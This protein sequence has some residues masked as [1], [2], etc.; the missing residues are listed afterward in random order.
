[1]AQTFAELGLRDE[2]ARAAAAAGYARP[3]AVQRGAIPVLRRGGNAVLHAS[4]GSGVLA[5]Y[6]LPLVDRLAVE[7]NVRATGPRALV[8]VPSGALA[9]PTATSMA[10][11]ARAVGLLVV[12]EGPGWPAIPADIM[13]LSVPA[14]LQGLQTSSL[15]LEQLESLVLDGLVASFGLFG[16]EAIESLLVTVPREA[17]RIIVAESA[18]S[19]VDDFVERHVRRAL[20]VPPRS[21]ADR[22][23]GPAARAPVPSNVLGYLIVSEIEKTATVAA[24]LST[25][26][27]NRN[28]L[29][30]CRT[31]LVADRVLSELS[32]RGFQARPVESGSSTLELAA[33]AGAGTG[34]APHISHDVPLDHEMLLERHPESGIVVVTPRELPHL[35]R[36][37][38][39]A[40]F[41]LQPLALHAPKRTEL[42]QFRERLRRAAQD[43]DLSA[44]IL[45]L[46]PLLEELS[47]LE[48]AAAAVGLL[49]RTP[50]IA[51]PASPPVSEPAA[52]VGPQPPA[53]VRLFISVGTRDNLRPGDLVGAITGEAA[54]PGPAVGRVDIRDTYSIVEVTSEH[55]EKVLQALNGVTLKGRSVRAD[56]DRKGSAG[57]SP[58][59]RGPGE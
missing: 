18:S 21:I 50:Q 19:E 31:P 23:A 34:A 7:Q 5:A 47:A 44:Q 24:L 12:G 46:E 51:T 43:E 29:L 57:S 59:R 17:Q 14:V 42:D 52:A 30:F 56:Y 48:L 32:L 8:V 35:R 49:R 45:I 40:Q 25:E 41:S 27:S 11:F 28:R 9:N 15:K 6:S 54:I 36:L 26:P 58:R 39:E 37:A 20:H 16:R 55:A 13:V 2:L 22:A 4:A 1:M 53:W 38:A 10:S 3:S 33:A